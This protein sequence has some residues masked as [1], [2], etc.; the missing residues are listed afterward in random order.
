VSGHGGTGKTFLWRT[1]IAKLRSKGMIVLAVASSG[2][3]A[4]LLLGGRTVHS[5]FKISIDMHDRSLCNIRRGTDLAG[6]I[7]QT[8]LV[9]WDEVLMSHRR[10]VECLDRTCG[11][12]YLKMRVAML[13][14]LLGVFLW[15]W[16]VIQ[17]GFAG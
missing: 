1:F 7:R 13:L 2:V 9:L 16:V 17:A 10:C 12:C 15:L 3:A 8:S 14:C 4:L 5:Q 11:M 6:L